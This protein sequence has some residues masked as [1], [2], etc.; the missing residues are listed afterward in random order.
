MV[1]SAIPTISILDPLAEIRKLNS[2]EFNK[3]FIDKFND[4]TMYSLAT[5]TDAPESRTA[6]TDLEPI[7]TVMKRFSRSSETLC[8]DFLIV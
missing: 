3:G 8:T 4:F 5:E 7:L 1:I 2:L 6:L